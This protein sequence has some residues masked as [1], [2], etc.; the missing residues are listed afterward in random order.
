[1]RLEDAVAGQLYV[2][3][4]LSPN[5]DCVSDEE[6]RR[7][8]GLKFKIHSIAPH[9]D[10]VG[11][12]FF[13]SNLRWMGL[14]ISGAEADLFITNH[15]MTQDY[16]QYTALLASEKSIPDA[17]V[18]FVIWLENSCLTEVQAK[19]AEDKQPNA[20]LQSIVD[21]AKEK[22]KERLTKLNE[23]IRS[24]AFPFRKKKED[25]KEGE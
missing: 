23:E 3:T 19:I 1:M 6:S 2:L 11:A 13:C 16:V 21:K 14:R 7:M 24:T 20:P 10:H 25:V 22:C 15:T 18:Q 17:Q 9:H 5:Q 12:E 4:K 8:L